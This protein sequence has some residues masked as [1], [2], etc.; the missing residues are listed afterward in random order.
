MKFKKIHLV[1]VT[2]VLAVGVL[3][4][5]QIESVVSGDNSYQQLQK[6]DEAFQYITK[7]YV[8]PVNSERL[9][10]NG[11]EGMLERLDPHS[12]YIN[13]ERMKEV[14]EQFNAEFEGIGI[15]YRVIEDT[16]QVISPITG[17][18]SEEVGLQPGDRI[19]K[20]NDSSAV[21]FSE[22]EVQ[23]HLKGP[24]GT[25]V[26]VTVHRPGYDSELDFTITRDK[27]P[28]QTVE[29][30]YMID[31]EIGYISMNR[32]A[33]TT[34]EEFKEAL[35]DL[36]SQGM[37]R[38]VLDLR[39]NP[40]GFMQMAI[41]ISN[42]FL[43]GDKQIVYT[44][45]R[46]SDF[47]K[48]YRSDDGGDFKDRPL[49][50]LVNE[51][52][53]SASEIVSG[54]M[55]DHDR[56]LIVGRR[57]FG[58]GLVQQQFPLSDGSVL[59]MTVS[60][61]YTPAG[62]LIQTPYDRDEEREDYY[63]DKVQRRFS[64]ASVDIREFV[65]NVPDSLVYSTDHGRTV[66]GGGGIIPDYVVPKDSASKFI[67][68]LYGK[69][70]LL[71]FVGQWIDRN[72][73]ELEQEWSGRKQEF[74]RD[75]SLSQEARDAFWAYAESQ[76]IEFVD[77]EAALPDTAADDSSEVRT[78]FVRSNIV[79]DEE[80]VYTYVKALLGRRIFDVSTRIQIQNQADPELREALRLWDRAEELLTMYHT[81]E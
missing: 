3:L 30:S 47:N 52:S 4:G 8:D 51:G 72:G 28:I 10:E 55:Q 63:R 40:G 26:D 35:T 13:A 67:Q 74:I 34:Y 66:Y 57:T 50:V 54:A 25:E 15:Y 81:Q 14:K 70:V 22:N 44:R 16:I 5:M 48:E 41:R 43:D 31:D 61:Y 79:A 77:S 46:H 71:G 36:K 24:K 2:A 73:E 69:N 42:E 12:V 53:A 33:R 49:I 68:A 62:R 17:G 75:F 18:P 1:V 37:E 7:R 27:I 6:L 19:I 32:F 78:T 38:L 20:V 58:K 59:Q 11:I 23:D 64:E 9:A 29:A 21:G 76:D 39:G 80:R 65:E 56:A 45:S 60:R